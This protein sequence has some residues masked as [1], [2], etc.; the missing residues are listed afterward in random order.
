[1]AFSVRITSIVGFVRAH[2]RRVAAA[3]GALVA[4]LAAAWW[5]GVPR[6]TPALSR[7]GGAEAAPRAPYYQAPFTAP[8]KAQSPVRAQVGDE[9]CGYG[10]VPVLDGVPHIPQ[11]IEAAAASALH[12][13]AVDLTARSTD[14]D[15]ALGM[16]LQMVEAWNAAGDSWV[17][18]HGTCANNDAACQSAAVDAQSTATAASRRALVRLATT[19]SDA[20]AY[21]LAMYSCRPAIGQPSIGDCALLSSAQWARIEPDNAVPWLYLAAEAQQQHDPSGIEAVVHR[22]S[23]SR[24]SDP[25][26]DLISRFLASDTYKEQ[27]PSIQP[28]LAVTLLGIQDAF[29]LPAFQVLTQYCRTAT[30]ADPK[31]ETCG[32]LAALL[33][34]HSRTLIEAFVGGKIAEKIGWTDPRFSALR[35]EVDALRWQFSRASKSS[36]QHILLSCESLQRLRRDMGT[37]AE[38]GEAE[39]LRR[40]LV[41]SGVT[42]SQAAQRWRTEIH[43]QE[44]QQTDGV[45][46]TR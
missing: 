41:E 44:I 36:E 45:E 19:T 30:Q 33:I 18:A 8:L 9:L 17:R 42:T 29:S 31:F 28:Q 7:S 46:L 16:Y 43:R 5:S 37:R 22:A 26:W 20:E 25:H 3:A 23:K 21:A 27:P 34:E 4:L 40:Q 39:S 11:D 14:R 13:I 1:M 24:Y 32:N 35:D 6:R 15:R 2:P 10:P 12:R 38:F